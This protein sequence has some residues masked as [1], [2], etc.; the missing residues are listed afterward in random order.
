MAKMTRRE[1]TAHRAVGAPRLAVFAHLVCDLPGSSFAFVMAT[2]IVSIGAG[3]LGFGRLAE[4]L[5]AI[6]LVAFPALSAAIVFRLVQRPSAFLAELRND[7]RGPGLLTIVA[8]ASVFGDQIWLLTSHRRIATGLLL[9]AFAI[10]VCLIYCLF[11]AAT[12]RTAKAP[13]GVAFDG[14][15]LLAVV[16]TESLAILGTEVKS[17]FSAPETIVF[18]SRC[19]FLLGGV[20]YLI[21]ITLILYRWLF[22]QM[23]PHQLTPSYW[24]NMGAAAITTLAA[25]QLVP[26]VHPYPVL[27]SSDAFLVGGTVLF[28]S[29]ASWWMP[30]LL[31]VMIW[32]HVSGVPLTYRFEYW[33]MVFP[34]G[35]YT[36]ATFSLARL[37]DIDGLF[38]NAR[39]F[40][41]IAVA[42]WCVVSLGMMRHLISILR[43]SVGGAPCRENAE[44]NRSE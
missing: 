29:V 5:L 13:P 4:I 23:R 15:W 1:T 10:W 30:L 39:V 19:L 37:I 25:V 12:I 34:L 16:A 28:W 18:A 27:A 43:L 40:I 11:A 36:V 7:R 33:S 21:I 6:N 41:W 31:A 42:A 8:G 22:E 20:F 26:A 9:A 44:Y 14:N 17:E 24:I 2:G 32:R 38:L 3:L 35:M